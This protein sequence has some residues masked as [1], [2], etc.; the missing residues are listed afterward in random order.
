VIAIQ[1][2]AMILSAIFVLF[3]LNGLNSSAYADPPID[4]GGRGCQQRSIR[5]R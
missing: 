5:R 4:K 3:P 1:P 2:I